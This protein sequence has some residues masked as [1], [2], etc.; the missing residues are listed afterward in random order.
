MQQRNG[1][2]IIG[3]SIMGVSENMKNDVINWLSEDNNPAVKYRVQI[4]MLGERAAKEPVI[5]WVKDFLPA[6]WQEQTGPW[7]TYY[8][9]AIAEC[10]LA[11]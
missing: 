7:S 10:G 1:L 11:Y 2:I 8:L 6:D 4:E 5:A 3:H 9:T